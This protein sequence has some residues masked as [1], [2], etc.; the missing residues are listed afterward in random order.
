LEGRTIG[1][2]A[3]TLEIDTWLV[4]RIYL[5]DQSKKPT[6]SASDNSAM[7][8]FKKTTALALAL[9]HA[10]RIAPVTVAQTT[11]PSPSSYGSE[12]PDPLH[13]L[14]LVQDGRFDDSTSGT[15]DSSW[16]GLSD[17]ERSV[18]SWADRYE[19]KGPFC[20]PQFSRASLPRGKVPHPSLHHPFRRTQ[21][22]RT[23]PS[24]HQVGI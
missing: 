21:R 3:N 20:K 23:K 19:A 4:T 5:S 11:T 7:L 14:A 13:V 12:F 6:D 1:L 8:P 16:T 18:L 17:A 10:L 24:S 2:F 22:S 9:I 15:I